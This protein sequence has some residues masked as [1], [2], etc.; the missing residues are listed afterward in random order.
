MMLSKIKNQTNQI[1]NWPHFENL[2]L[3]LIILNSITLALETSKAASGAA[4]VWLLYIDRVFLSIFVIEILLRLAADFRGFWRDP[5]RIF[6]FFVVTIALLPSTGPLS[7]LRALRILRVLRLISA[8]PA[9][10]SY[11]HL[12]LPTICSV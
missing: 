2:I 7:I 4:G 10:V 9:T 12:T 6:D 5:W 3:I 11:T 8:V 1:L